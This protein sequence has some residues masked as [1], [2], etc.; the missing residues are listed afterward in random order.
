MPQGRACSL[1][2]VYGF[3]LSIAVKGLQMPEKMERRNESAIPEAFIFPHGC[4][5]RGAL[6]KFWNR[7]GPQRPGWGACAVAALLAGSELSAQPPGHRLWVPL[8]GVGEGT[9][10]GSPLPELE[11]GRRSIRPCGNMK[12]MSLGFS[13]VC[14]LEEMS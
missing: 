4:F 1:L 12:K 2:L 3:S 7:L 5:S 14:S 8:R 13:A 6:S 11:G 10:M 9:G